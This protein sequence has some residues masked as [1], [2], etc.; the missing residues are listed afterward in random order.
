MTAAALAGAAPGCGGDLDGRPGPDGGGG[1]GAIAGS[2]SDGRPPAVILFIGDG[3]GAGQ[4]DAASLY[5]HGARGGLAMQRLAHVGQVRTASASGI[6]DSAAAA[7]AMATGVFTYNGRVGVDRDG[8]PAATLIERASQRGWASG[9]VT[10]TSLSHATPAGFTSHVSSRGLYTDIAAQMVHATH[11][12]VMLGGGAAYF[13]QAL[14]DELSAGGYNQVTTAAE[15]A[16]AVAARAPRLFGAFTPYD[17]TFVAARA[18]GTTEPTLAD[19]TAA[20]LATLSRDPHGFFLMVEGGRIDHGGHANSLVDVVH[21]TLAFDDAVAYGIAW[22][23]GRG[24][25]TVMVTADHETGGLEVVQEA[26]AGEYPSVRWRWGNHTNDRVSLFAEGPGTEVVSHAV[27]DHR[28]VYELACARLDNRAPVAPAPEPIPDGELGDLR[29][30]AAIQTMSSDFGAGEHQL[31]A[32]WLDATPAGLF[33]G[34]EGVFGWTGSAVQVWI[35]ADP[36]TG[37]GFA[38]PSGNITDQTGVADAAL[39]ASRLAAPPV[40]FGADVALVS[41]G[42]ADPMLEELRDDGGLRALRQPAGQP[43]NLGWLPAAINF[44]AVRARPGESRAPATGHG[45]EAFVPWAALYPEGAPPAGAR[46]RLAVALVSATGE[47]TSN[48]FL[49]PLPPASGSPGTSVVALPGVIEYVLDADLD[50]AVD[51]DQPPFALP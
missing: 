37:T 4:I 6:T 31:D 14:H 23:R 16:A 17:M 30:R 9:V 50:G 40:P 27:V 49:P 43:D 32:L 28:W 36:S 13:D 2:A 15:L 20:A 45:L 46:L 1:D 44:G 39:A 3:M 42:G 8:A 41:V 35:D 5:R 34:V 26:R 11:P 51:G 19:M 24:N 33:V 7:T 12:D 18:A 38:S 25:V 29:H 21:D 48:Q 22:A 10:T 47:L